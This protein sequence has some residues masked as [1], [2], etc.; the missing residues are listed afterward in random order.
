MGQSKIRVDLI[1]SS[2]A[3]DAEKA[4]ERAKKA[5]DVFLEPL[6]TQIASTAVR[7]G[8]RRGSSQAQTL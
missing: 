6:D 3:E 2:L 5:S 8:V 7:C 4:Q 1:M